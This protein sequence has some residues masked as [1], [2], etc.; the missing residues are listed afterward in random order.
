[1]TGTTKVSE[2]LYFLFQKGSAVTPLLQKG[3]KRCSPAAAK[4]G[5]QLRKDV[6]KGPSKSFGKGLGSPQ[7]CSALHNYLAVQAGWQ[8]KQPVPALGTVKLGN[9]VHIFVV[10]LART[11]LNVEIPEDMYK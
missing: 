10:A 7:H 4:L 9:D 11:V 2:C 1:M 3:Y 8:N 5:Y 6:H